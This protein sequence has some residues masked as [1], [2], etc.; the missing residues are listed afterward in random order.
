MAKKCD[1]SRQER[2][3][4]L[5]KQAGYGAAKVEGGGKE[6]T[7]AIVQSA[8]SKKPSP[9][10]GASP[11]S[12][13][14]KRPRKA[15]GGSVSGGK[16]AKTE[17]NIILPGKDNA[18]AG[19]M[20]PIAP[21]GGAMPP[22]PMPPVARPPMGGPPPGG[23]PPGAMRKG[24]RVKESYPIESGSGGGEGRRQKAAAAKKSHKG[25]KGGGRC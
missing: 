8:T 14:D 3:Q 23:M 11:M 1:Y 6:S 5:M 16:N 13:G 7:K 22:R 25:R 21:P 2:A 10:S 12:R 20:P 19:P 15:S 17:I 4:K 18:P 24:G 9:V